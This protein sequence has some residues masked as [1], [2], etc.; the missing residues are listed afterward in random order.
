MYTSLMSRYEPMDLV[1]TAYMGRVRIT[2]FTHVF[3]NGRIDAARL[4]DA[5]TQVGSIV[6][7]T[8]CRIDVSH[9]RYVPIPP[10]ARTIL[11]EVQGEV[12]T[13]PVWDPKTDTQVKIL[14]GHGKDAD[15]IIVGMSHV[16]SD[17]IGLEQYVYLLAA[18]YNG[19]LPK[20]RNFRSLDPILKGI[21]VG[22]PTDGEKTAAQIGDQPFS[23]PSSGNEPF[24]R[25]VTIPAPTMALLHDKSREMGV[26]LNDVFVAACVRVA[27]R[28]LQVPVVR[29]PCPVDYRRFGDVGPLS[30]ANM[31]GLYLS[32]FPVGPGDSFSTTTQLVNREI[33]EL[34]ARNRCFSTTVPFMSLAKVLPKSVLRWLSVKSYVKPAIT[35]SNFGVIKP[36]SFGEA[37]AVSAFMTGV[38]RPKPQCSLS[39]SSY[40]G[41]TS[42]VSTLLGDNAYADACENV[43]R[44]IVQE[45]ES[46]LE[47]AS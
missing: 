7:E 12:Q 34:R 31:S 39:V 17:G 1:E 8:L 20:V 9:M 35:Y 47:E 14:V 13:G 11:Q 40:Q 28:I 4:E 18:A 25:C 10:S 45:C 37:Q 16:L 22:D 15:S 43:I 29:L 2:I 26:H 23:F 30:V 42:F 6:P 46:W 41:A 5:V 33:A 27:A 24:C 36:L 38:Y 3:L 44:Q 21:H 32:S 19:N